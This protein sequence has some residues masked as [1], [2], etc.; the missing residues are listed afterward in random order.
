MYLWLVT[1]RAADH[2]HSHA[3]QALLRDHL[4][5]LLYAHPAAQRPQLAT[6]INCAGESTYLA[7]W[8][9]IHTVEAFEAS[10]N[11]R[12]LLDELTSLLRMPPK[13]ELWKIVAD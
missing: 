11:Y 3:I 4:L 6:C 10:S 7:H 9:D 5:P 2:H 12:A 8:P 13:R 1:L